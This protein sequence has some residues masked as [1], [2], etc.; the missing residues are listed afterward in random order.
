MLSRNECGLF[1][2][3]LG[4]YF[5]FLIVG[6]MNIG[7]FGSLLKILAI[8]PAIIWIIQRH[9]IIKNRCFFIA[10]VFVG[11]CAMSYLWSVSQENTATRISTQV[12]FILLLAASSGYTYNPQEIQ[13]LKKSLIW[14]SRLTAVLVLLFGGHYEGRITLNGLIRED[15]NY[16]CAYFL[17]GVAGAIIVLLGQNCK[18]AKIIAAFELMVYIYIVF[19]TGSRGGLLA[20]VACG[21]ITL[22]LY[23]NRDDTTFE[24]IYKRVGIIAIIILALV[25][26]SAFL[27][28]AVLERFSLDVLS[29]SEGTGRYDLWQDAINAYTN[30]NFLRQSIGYGSATAIPVTYLFPFSRH[31]VYHNMFVETLVELGAV[32]I[33]LYVLHIFSFVRVTIIKRDFFSFAIISSMVVLSLST[34]ISV[35][36][37]YWNIMIFILCTTLEKADDDNEN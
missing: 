19:A 21:I 26:V 18:K 8:I 4:I 12:T 27:E 37:P 14:S 17:F 11:F 23:K 36:K 2:K 33:L 20:I 32:G 5:S 22:L 30:S 10:I 29:K 24:R 16:L 35:F 1:V 7:A 9:S 34:S 25:F 3:W 28:S 15:P 13:Y 31:N 6:A